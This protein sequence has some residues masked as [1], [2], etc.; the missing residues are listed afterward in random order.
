MNRREMLATT[1]AATLA[2]LCKP[3]LMKADAPASRVAI[4][5]CPDYAQYEQQLSLAF[6]QI[7]GIEKLMRGKTVALKL[8]LTGNPKNWPLTPELPYR[9]DPQ[10]VSATVHLFAKAGARRVRMIESF[11]PADQDLSLWARY[12]LDVKAM[13]TT[14]FEESMYHLSHSKT[15][16]LRLLDVVRGIDQSRVEEFRDR[17]QYEQLEM[18]ILNALTGRS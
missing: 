2:A 17:R 5:R 18:M 4:V 14:T 1:S 15:M 8:N 13:R 16:F 12:G 9:T 3:T 7:G 6:D 11:F 10:S